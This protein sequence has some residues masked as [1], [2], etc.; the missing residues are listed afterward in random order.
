MLVVRRYMND[1]R[2]AI[3]IQQLYY[4]TFLQDINSRSVF[5]FR[6][7]C[8]SPGSYTE[9]APAAKKACLIRQAF[10]LFISERSVP[11]HSLPHMPAGTRQRLPYI[12]KDNPVP[13]Q[14]LRIRPAPP[15]GS[16]G[17]CCGRHSSRTFHSCARR[18][19]GLSLPL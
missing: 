3:P 10:L 12:G 2:A 7:S 17:K 14:T 19:T 18:Q 16:G 5:F 9:A 13:G 4:S 6:F 15:P 1:K 11:C 8:A